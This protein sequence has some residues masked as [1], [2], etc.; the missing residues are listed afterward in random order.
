MQVLN[1]VHSEMLHFRPPLSYPVP[2]LS[3]PGRI[4]SRTHLRSKSLEIL[5]N[6]ICTIW[7]YCGISF[8]NWNRKKYLKPKWLTRLV[9]KI[10]IRYPKE[11]THETV[12]TVDFIS[13]LLYLRA[14]RFSKWFHSLVYFSSSACFRGVYMHA[15]KESENERSWVTYALVRKSRTTG[16]TACRTGL[17][18][19]D[20]NLSVKLFY[21]P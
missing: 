3:C 18:I 2:V 9:E 20:D 11:V 7:I 5:R 1:T 21:Y 15:K 16:S 8:K 17:V 19:P 4:L 14:H 12:V 6:P 13:I 10:H